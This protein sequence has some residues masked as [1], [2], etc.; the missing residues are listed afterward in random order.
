VLA[1][2]LRPGGK[3]CGPADLVVNEEELPP[4]VLTRPAEWAD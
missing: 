1:R 4:E 3:L 2:V